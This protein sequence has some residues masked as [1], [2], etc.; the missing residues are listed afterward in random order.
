MMGGCHRHL[1]DMGRNVRCSAAVRTVYTTRDYLT[2]LSNK[3]DVHVCENLIHN[4]QGWASNFILYI[5]TK[6]GLF[7]FLLLAL[8]HIEFL[9][10][11][12]L[13]EHGKFCSELY[14]GLFT[15][16]ENNI[17]NGNASHSSWVA[18]KTHVNLCAFVHCGGFSCCR[19]WSLGL[20]VVAVYTFFFFRYWR[21]YHF[22]INYFSLFLE[23]SAVN[24]WFYIFLKLWILE[25]KFC[26]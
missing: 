26:V 23:Y 15:I 3:L 6:V 10:S 9:R 19:A 22:T 18:F 1:V 2:W 17:T 11:A 7:C 4:Y 12:R 14:W 13:D 25:G 20:T 16:L 8:T 24:V 21:I 5:N